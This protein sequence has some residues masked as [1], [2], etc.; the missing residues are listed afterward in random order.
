MEVVST[1]VHHGDR[2]GR[3]ALCNQPSLTW[4]LNRC[5]GQWFFSQ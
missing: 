3:A 5:L 2:M 4:Y 1:N